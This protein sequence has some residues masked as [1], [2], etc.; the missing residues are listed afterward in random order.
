MLTRMK[1]KIEDI[2]K[3]T[4][5]RT[6]VI[7]QA[8][9]NADDMTIEIAFASENKI[10][11]WFGGEILNISKDSMRMQRL[12]DGAPYLLNHDPDKQ[13]GVVERAW[14]GD[15]RVARAKIRFSKNALGQEVFRDIQDGIKKHVSFGYKIHKLVLES[16]TDTESVYRIMDFEPYEIS[17]CVIPADITVGIGR[18]LEIIEPKEEAKTEPKIEIV[19]SKLERGFSMDESMQKMFNDGVAQENKRVAELSKVAQDNACMH[20]LR[21]AIENKKTVSEFM[22]DVLENTKTRTQ[23]MAAKGEVFGIPKKE[24]RKFSLFRALNYID[25]GRRDAAPFEVEFSEHMQ[26]VLKRSTPGIMVPSHLLNS[27]AF[28]TTVGSGGGIIQDTVMF[29]EFIPMLRASTV[30]SRL[31]ARWLTGLSGIFSLPKQT[32]GSAAYW[33]SEGDATGLTASNFTTGQTK[34]QS[35]NSC[36]FCR[37]YEKIIEAR[38]F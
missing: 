20:L 18:S 26:S 5:F 6:A 31:G 7:E 9:I 1:V 15:D 12:N 37:Y 24:L 8:S 25:T 10:D 33:L 23:E 11:R 36:D 16:E 19:S 38:K 32:G 27:R 35:Q 34:N 28:N 17:Q 21:T 3:K 14:I 22:Y 29:D 13:I 4:Q 2:L 30:L